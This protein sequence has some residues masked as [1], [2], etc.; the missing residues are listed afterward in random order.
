VKPRRHH[1][2]GFAPL[3]PS[4]LRR[5]RNEY[6]SD[7]YWQTEKALGIRDALGGILADHDRDGFISLKQVAAVENILNFNAGQREWGIAKVGPVAAPP[8]MPKKRTATPAPIPP[9]EP[10]PVPEPAPLPLPMEEPMPAPE[11]PDDRPTP[12]S[13]PALLVPIAL[14]WEYLG[15]ESRSR[16]DRLIHAGIFPPPTSYVGKQAR[17]DVAA[18]KAWVDAHPEALAAG[19]RVQ[20]V[21]TIASLR[22][23]VQRL[24]ARIAELEADL[25]RTVAS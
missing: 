21:E 15:F 2:K 24:E 19:T 10:A 20:P 11:P 17:W 22:A 25:A 4:V 13:T 1:P 7:T 8:Q 23:K 12:P 5:A 9:P 14:L 6:A 3:D 16:L 18:A